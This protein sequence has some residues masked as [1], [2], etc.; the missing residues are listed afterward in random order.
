MKKILA[1]FLIMVLSFL[2][3]AA[4][5]IATGRAETTNLPNSIG[6]PE[7]YTNP[8]RY[9][10]ALPIEGQVLEGK[11]T[12]VRFAPYATPELYDETV[13]FCGDVAG[14]FDGKSGPMVVT[15]RVQ[16]SHMYKGIGCHQLLSVF[17]VSVK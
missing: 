10:L 11:Y 5:L 1:A 4:F 9:L 7:V 12:N 8:Y 15:Y 6:A 13:L 16:A 2:V 14:E 3:L 17:E